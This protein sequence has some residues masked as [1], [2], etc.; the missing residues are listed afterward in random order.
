MI[1]IVY[2]LQGQFSEVGEEVGI[3]ELHETP[4]MMGGGVVA[5]DYNNDGFEDLYLTDPGVHDHL[6]ENLGDGTFGEVS[7]ISRIASL[8]QDIY[9]FGVIAGDIN[10]DGCDDL[11]IS[12]FDREQSNLLLLN[13]CDG[14]F[15]DISISAGITH[16]SA[17]SGATFFDYNEDGLLDIYVINYIDNFQFI[18]DE[19]DIIIDIDRTCFPNFFYINQGGNQ[20]IERAAEYGMENI[21]CGL[22]VVAT[23]F[24]LDGDQDIYI[25]NDHGMHVVP[26][27]LYR[28]NYPEDS[29]EDAAEELNMNL[30]MFG[31]GI[32]LGDF[33]EDGRNDFYLSNLGD[34]SL[35][36]SQGSVYEDVASELNIKNGYYEQDTSVTSWGTFFFDADNDSDLDLYVAN[37]YIRTGYFGFSTTLKDRNTFFVNDGVGGY[38][39]ETMSYQ[40]ND[41]SIARGA[42]QFDYNRDGKVDFFVVN[43]EADNDVKSLFYR[44]D[45]E[46]KN[47]IELKLEAAEGSNRSAFGSI[48]SVYLE[49]K[50]YMKELHSGGTFASQHSQI[51]HFGLGEAEEADSIR[52]LW[53]NGQME[54]FN[55]VKSNFI[56]K[57]LQNSNKIDITGCMDESAENFYEIATYNTAC[58]YAKSY[59][60]TDTYATNYNSEA[61]ADDG[62]CEYDIPLNTGQP[63]ID[64]VSVYPNPFNRQITIDYLDNSPITQGAKRIQVYNM[65][66][67]LMIERDVS[68]VNHFELD[69]SILSTG[70]YQLNIY[71]GSSQEVIYQTKI[72]KLR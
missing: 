64:K 53:P 24:D 41:S 7:V 42:A 44:N 21:G 30:G 55:D 61:T 71:Q 19:N 23:D 62:T 28:N 17:S 33:N 72:V 14:T 65:A 49:D 6:F 40:L 25:S 31:M 47:W 38:E 3:S 66:G 2:D 8:T 60:C 12:T 10:N 63:Y 67:K 52:I 45:F 68:I 34:N 26:N 32:A 36:K 43:T 46:A 35:L 22:S 11:F 48:V 13:Q 9:S 27:T 1:L 16:Q 70:I 39:D 50:E 69:V 56:Y 4:V 54:Q 15:E 5:F 18:K 59:G 29:F 57:V 20:F 58:F 37:G 51:L